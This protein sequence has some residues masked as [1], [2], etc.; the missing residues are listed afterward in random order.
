[1]RQLDRFFNRLIEHAHLVVFFHRACQAAHHSD[2]PRDFGFLDLD[3]LEAPLEGGIG[4]E[5]F[6]VFHPGGGRD[7]AQLAAGQRWLEQIGCIVL[8]GRPAGADHGVGFINEQDDRLRRTL[9]LGDH[10]L[11]PIFELTLDAG[12]GL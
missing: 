9:H 2:G 7:R 8:P 1:M 10:L 11:E 3:D 6:L 5:V 4:L 12:A